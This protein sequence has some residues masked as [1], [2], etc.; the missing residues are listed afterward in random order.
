[1]TPAGYLFHHA[2][3]IHKK[4]RGVGILLHDVL[5]CETRLR[6]QAILF[7]N[8]QLTFVSGGISL[9]VAIIYRLC[10]TKQNDFK[11]ANFFKEFSGFVNSLATNS[12]H[13]LILG[14]FNIH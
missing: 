5:K 8:Y 12:V 4:G 14:N 3:R 9:R 2:V 1:V 6:F 11:A 13:L 7:L 10:P